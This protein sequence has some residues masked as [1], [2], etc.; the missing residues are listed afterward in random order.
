M[1]ELLDVNDTRKNSPDSNMASCIMLIV[2]QS[3]VPEVLIKVKDSV[4][5]VKSRNSEKERGRKR[6]REGGGR[7]H[8]LMTHMQKQTTITLDTLCRASSCRQRDGEAGGD[9][10]RHNNTYLNRTC[11]LFNRVSIQWSIKADSCMYQ[12]K[13]NGP[14]SMIF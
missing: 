1:L 14:S 11:A 10:T 3:V 7:D 6:E 4:I 8:S 13:F 5:G 12:N 2:A 9:S